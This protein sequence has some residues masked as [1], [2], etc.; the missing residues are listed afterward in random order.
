MWQL[1]THPHICKHG[2]PWHHPTHTQVHTSL[3][4]VWNHCFS[5]FTEYRLCCT[6][7]TLFK[8]LGITMDPVFKTYT[9]KVGKRLDK[10]HT[11]SISYYWLTQRLISHR[12]LSSCINSL[13]IAGWK[14]LLPLAD[15]CRNLTAYLTFHSSSLQ[16]TSRELENEQVIFST[17]TMKRKITLWSWKRAGGEKNVF[18][19]H[20]W[21]KITSKCSN[22][23]H[24]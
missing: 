16:I 7:V 20:L 12:K 14:T 5:S 2:T 21:H 22:Y 6:P 4:L 9:V 24:C 23:Q 3:S 11:G 1:Y 13:W 17:K 19:S 18:T 10:T 15:H 8:T